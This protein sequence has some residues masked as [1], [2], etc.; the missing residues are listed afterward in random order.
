MVLIL[1]H[2]KYIISIFSF[3]VMFYGMMVGHTS[4]LQ[5]VYSL[6]ICFVDVCIVLLLSQLEC[7]S[8]TQGLNIYILN[9]LIVLSCIR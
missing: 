3:H 8:D 5:R 1:I 4:F 9:K 6:C 7:T 2:L